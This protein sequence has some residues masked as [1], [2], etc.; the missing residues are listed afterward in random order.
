LSHVDKADRL[1]VRL[2][3]C[4]LA[5]VCVCLNIACPGISSFDLFFSKVWERLDSQ[6]PKEALSPL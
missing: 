3:L 2:R 1:P 6:L 4:L 5:F